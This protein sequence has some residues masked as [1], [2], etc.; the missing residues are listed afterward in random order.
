M[1]DFAYVAIHECGRI[2]AASVD[3]PDHKREVARDIG[4]WIRRGE[5]VE[6]LPLDQVRKA[7]WCTCYRKKS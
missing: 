7:A 2:V 1:S 5:A 3:D 6:R 4:G